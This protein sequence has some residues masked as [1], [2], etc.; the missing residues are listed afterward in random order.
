M[1][2]YHILTP[3]VRNYSMPAC[4][5]VD[6]NNAFTTSPT[7]RLAINSPFGKLREETD[8]IQPYE[9]RPSVSFDSFTSKPTNYQ[10]FLT[11]YATKTLCTY[12]LCP[13]ENHNTCTRS[14]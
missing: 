5:V 14:R 1:H 3:L 9:T 7:V 2:E 6:V 13:C 11:L 10:G 12:L 8:H 4:Q